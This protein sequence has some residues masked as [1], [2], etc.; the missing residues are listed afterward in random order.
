LT[1]DD[2]N[3]SHASSHSSSESTLSI[4]HVEIED[5]QLDTTKKSSGF[6]SIGGAP[7]FEGVI[8]I[9]TLVGFSS[10]SEI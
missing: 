10:V 2:L 1:M 8:D 9:G 7:V 4:A 6:V 3:L 5:A